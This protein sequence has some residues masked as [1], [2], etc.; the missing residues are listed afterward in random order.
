MQFIVE[1]GEGLEE[2]NS[3]VSVIEADDY[4]SLFYDEMDSEWLAMTEDEKEIF[5]IRSTN[6]VD[7]LI[8][9]TSSLKSL[10]QSLNWPR[11]P[12]RDREGRT[13]KDVPRAIKEA[14]IET[15]FASLNSN[16]FEEEFNITREMYGSS[17]VDYAGP[18]K[19]GGNQVIREITSKL[20][21]LGY[22]VRQSNVITLERA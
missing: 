14:T 15:A 19:V 5:L 12:F 17:S 1:T 10:E 4:I 8:R 18:V 11:K 13:V 3:Y 6:Y 2:A 22:G 9:Y 20:L 7:D 21:R 16:I